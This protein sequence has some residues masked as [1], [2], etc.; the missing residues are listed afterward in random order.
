MADES[1]QFLGL[2]SASMAG[3]FNTIQDV[4]SLLYDA[5]SVAWNNGGPDPERMPSAS[6]AILASPAARGKTVRLALRGF[7]FP[8]GDGTVRLDIGGTAATASPSEES[9]SH[10][11]TAT[12]SADGDVT[13]VTVTL[14]L[15][16]PADASATSL[17]LDSIDVSLAG[18]SDAEED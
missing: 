7:A 11:V 18:C 2:A 16:R 3:S 5:M 13:R 17:A 12:L 15:P 9:F 6:F 14:D 1:A 8:A 10:I 4:I